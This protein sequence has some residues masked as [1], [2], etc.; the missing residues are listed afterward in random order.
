MGWVE[1]FVRVLKSDSYEI[2]GIFIR[3]SIWFGYIVM[4]CTSLLNWVIAE[5]KILKKYL[6]TKESF[7][8][9]QTTTVIY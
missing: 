6:P 4:H 1:D 9:K 3:L 5:G 8:Y 7:I 2:N